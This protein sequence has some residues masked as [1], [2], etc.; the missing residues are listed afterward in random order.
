MRA[1][2]SREEAIYF[3]DWFKLSFLFHFFL[4]LYFEGIW[5]LEILVYEE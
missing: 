5:Y 1:T 4:P 3:V 2:D